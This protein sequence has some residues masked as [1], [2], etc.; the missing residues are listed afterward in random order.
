MPPADATTT[1]TTTTAESAKCPGNG[2]RAAYFQPTW[3]KYNGLS[4]SFLFLL[5]LIILPLFIFLLLI[6]TVVP[7]AEWFPWRTVSAH[8]PST[9]TTT[10]TDTAS[11]SPFAAGVQVLC[12]IRD[13]A[14]PSDAFQWDGSWFGHPGTELID[15]YAGTPTF[16]EMVDAGAS[17]VEIIEHFQADVML[18]RERRMQFLLY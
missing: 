3:S 16:R 4:L 18:F 7:G 13:L 10:T 17:A 5:P 14:V 8:Y 15:F 2:F 6:G 12:A 11:S 9:I 1:P